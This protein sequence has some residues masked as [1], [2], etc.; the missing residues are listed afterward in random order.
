MARFGS[1]LAVDAV[2]G[3]L[4]HPEILVV[5]RY[6]GKE[7]EVISRTAKLTDAQSAAIGKLLKPAGARYPWPDLEPANVD[8]LPGSLIKSRSPPSFTELLDDPFVAG[9]LRQ[10]T[11]LA[12]RWSLSYCVGDGGSAAGLARYEATTARHDGFRRRGC[13]DAYQFRYR[14]NVCGDGRVAGGRIRAS[15]DGLA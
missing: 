5:G 7:F 15:A 14:W 13:T 2:T 3:S 4:Q 11:G 9:W 1:L 12:R 8:T 6:R 10:W